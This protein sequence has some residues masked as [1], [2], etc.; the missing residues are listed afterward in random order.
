VDIHTVVPGEKA[1][2]YANKIPVPGTSYDIPY[3]C[4][5]PAKVDNLLVAGRC[6][7]ATHEALGSARMMPSCMAMGQA[8]GTAA[9]LA[10]GQNVSP[11]NLSVPALQKM[12]R[13]QGAMI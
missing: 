6:F 8:A 7:S 4:L 10:A 13:Q 11:R 9:A 2:P 12:L 3:R 5:L 1:S